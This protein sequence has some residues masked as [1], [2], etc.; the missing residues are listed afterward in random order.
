MDWQVGAQAFVSCPGR[1]AAPAERSFFELTGDPSILVSAV[2][3]SA[4]REDQWVLRLWNCSDRPV[5]GSLELRV[6]CAGGWWVDLL[7]QPQS[8]ARCDGNRI[9]LELGA[10]AIRS[11]ALQLKP[12]VVDSD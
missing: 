10:K 1:G 8:E 12:D 6:G 4:V 11:L 2:K 3:R 7:D 9:T 5:V